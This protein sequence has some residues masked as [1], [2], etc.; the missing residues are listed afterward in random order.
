[1]YHRSSG[2]DGFG[3][4]GKD[5]PTTIVFKIIYGSEDTDEVAIDVQRVEWKESLLE[6]V[7]ESVDKIKDLQEQMDAIKRGERP[8]DA[9]SPPTKKKIGQRDQR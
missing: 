6:K 3:A 5:F 1:M 2:R 9:S 8:E 4:L 7:I